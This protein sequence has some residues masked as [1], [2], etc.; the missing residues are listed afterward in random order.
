MPEDL[1]DTAGPDGATAAEPAATPLSP[2][3]AGS[4][5]PLYL[6]GIMDGHV[7]AACPYENSVPHSP[8]ARCSAH[9]A[10]TP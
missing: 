4:R 5:R 7:G 8:S 3:Q 9:D 10:Q 1:T 2:P 6:G